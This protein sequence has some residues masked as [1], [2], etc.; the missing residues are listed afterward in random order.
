MIKTL[1]ACAAFIAVAFAQV[2]T[3]RTTWTGATTQGNRFESYEL[4]PASATQMCSTSTASVTRTSGTV[5]SIGTGSSAADPQSFRFGNK[6]RQITAAVT[7]TVTSGSS[8]G[9]LSVYG[10][11][12]G[13]TLGIGVINPTGNT[14]SC[15]G[16]VTA[17][18][19]TTTA[20][21]IINNGTQI[22]TWTMTSG[23]LDSSGGTQLST[24]KDCWV[25]QLNISNNTA[26]AVTLTCTDSQSSPVAGPL[27]PTVSLPAN[28]MTLVVWPGGKY[29]EGGM[30]LTAGTAN[31]LTVTVR[32]G[33]IQ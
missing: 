27:C 22:W 29:F 18:P 20:Q 10:Y 25:D 14:I 21:N 8:T 13:S 17:A 30:K 4:L 2:D 12:T 15:S 3:T 11:M 9:T 16:C 33:R 26:S 32:G 1:A 23:S 31:A 7:A 19:G 24:D 28:G 5:L 6:T